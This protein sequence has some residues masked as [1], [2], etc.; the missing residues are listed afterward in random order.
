MVLK[1]NSIELGSVLREINNFTGIIKKIIKTE[2]LYYDIIDILQI[3]S[4]SSHWVYYNLIFAEQNISE[5]EENG[6]IIKSL[7]EE[8]RKSPNYTIS[9]I[10]M[11]KSLIYIYSHFFIIIDT[12]SRISFPALKLKLSKK[13]IRNLYICPYE[14][15]NNCII[16]NK[17]LL[18]FKINIIDK[19]YEI[20]NFRNNFTH[21]HTWFSYVIPSKNID[22]QISKLYRDNKGINF[23]EEGGETIFTT[24]DFDSNIFEKYGTNF[25]N[26]ELID[27]KQMLINDFEIVK[28]FINN[29]TTSS[30]NN[31]EQWFKKIK[32][33]F[34][35]S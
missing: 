29:I 1:K 30:I 27:L 33:Y 26:N 7:K 21:Y 9:K 24:R 5:W 20:R 18:N 4:L 8:F 35:K 15:L 16:N 23:W 10:E 12:G 2:K 19:I 3:L 6:K 11:D 13:Y 22:I 32:E 31:F 28:E 34:N 14:F 17:N 25:K